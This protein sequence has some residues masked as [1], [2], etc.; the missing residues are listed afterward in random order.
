V[1]GDPVFVRGTRHGNSPEV[2]GWLLRSAC[3]TLKV[4]FRRHRDQSGGFFLVFGSIL[5]N[6]SERSTLANTFAP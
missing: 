2:E 6:L 3:S 4:R 1:A 5:D